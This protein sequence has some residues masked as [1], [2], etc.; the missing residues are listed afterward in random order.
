MPAKKYIY[1]NVHRLKEIRQA[2]RAR[3]NT[4]EQILWKFLRR[5][6]LGYKFRRQFSIGNVVVDVCNEPLRLVI[7][8]DGWTHGY[9]K[10]QAKD[11]RKER[12]LEASGYKVIRFKNERVYGDIGKLVDEISKICRERALVA[13]QTP[14]IPPPAP[15]P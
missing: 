9:E 14:V 8:I 5:N 10:T 4:A 6:Q 15:S 7:E 2:L 12:F 11:E 3:A 1:K 13:K